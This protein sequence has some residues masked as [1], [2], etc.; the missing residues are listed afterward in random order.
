MDGV[1]FVKAGDSVDEESTGHISDMALARF[2]YCIPYLICQIA[3][4]PFHNFLRP[5]GLIRSPMMTQGRSRLMR[6]SFVLER[7]TV[8]R[9]SAIFPP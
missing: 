2:N 9:F 6:T 5:A 8:V 4:L 3:S 1:P 7:T